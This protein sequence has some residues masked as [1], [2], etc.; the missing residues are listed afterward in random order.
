M[1]DQ[2]VLQCPDCRAVVEHMY[3]H[4][5]R[6]QRCAVCR[7]AHLR[8]QDR[9]K[10][11]RKRPQWRKGYQPR[12]RFTLEDARTIRRAYA[13][14]TSGVELA[15]QYNTRPETIN[16]IVQQKVHVDRPGSEP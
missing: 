14:G 10:K 6:P 7:D 2:P 5:K 13:A 9:E 8:A 1:Y 3:A 16:R 4:G 12:V 15:R 11:R